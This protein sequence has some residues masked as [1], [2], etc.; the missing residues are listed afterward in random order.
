M[1]Y[2]YTMD[3]VAIAIFILLLVF[4]WGKRKIS[5]QIYVVYYI[6]IGSML[7]STIM[8]VVVLQTMQDVALWGVKTLS[9]ATML[10]ILLQRLIITSCTMY[11]ISL[12]KLDLRSNVLRRC[13]VTIPYAIMALLV[14]FSPW[15]H[16]IFFIDVNGSFHSGSLKILSSL[17]GAYYLAICAWTMFRYRK[18]IGFDKIIFV[19]NNCA[20]IFCTYF[21]QLMMKETRIFALMMALCMIGVVYT[22]QRPDEV[23]DETN[24]LYRD[25]FLD[26]VLKDYS[27]KKPFFVIFIRIH[28]YKILTDS[29][30]QDAVNEILADVTSF[31]TLFTKGTNV[32]RTD[33]DILAIKTEM[34]NEEQLNS[35]VRA[36]SQRFKRIWRNGNTK[37]MLSASFIQAKCP[38]EV[39]NY[40][41]FIRLLGIIERKKGN[42]DELIAAVELLGQDREKEIIEA[43]KRGLEK[44]SFEV[45]YQPIYSTKYKKIIAA[46]ALVR[47]NDEKLGYISPEIMVPIAEREG[48]ILDIGKMV[49]TEVC[50]FYKE[51]NLQEK[52]IEYIE[53]NL[54]VKQC[55]Q[56][57]LAEDFLHI[58]KKYEIDAKQINFEI[59]ESSAMT[60]NH[61]VA[62]NI[63]EFEKN[64]VS[65]SLDDYG[66]GYSN[67][68]YLYQLPFQ[69][70]K[71]DKSILW[72]SESN[73][74]ADATLRNIFEMSKKLDL[75][76]VVEGVETEEQIS[77]LL[78]LGCDYFQ[79]YFFS[80]PVTGKE[81]IKY[82][83]DF[84]LPE[85]CR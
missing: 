47:L 37:A 8:D 12:A 15:T 33:D 10:Y 7:F 69:I 58:M 25:I 83:N 50:R 78:S 30:G 62:N 9:V 53:V 44:K 80:K 55:M 60:T 22:V 29:V 75:H 42:A 14:V 24:A 59:T 45:H 3:Y 72:S 85:I 27:S 32:F 1:Q 74:K 82:V 76:V 26:E 43:I 56:H 52:G 79:G 70:L 54:S 36:I 38:G 64:G 20:V 46:E 13:S 63:S 67:V 5:L 84:Q 68:S 35:T 40:D 65:L 17:Y 71:V 41:E 28:D 19:L 34:M 6:L 31:L 4:F 61:V 66:T 73:K 48:Y 11:V 21:I 23:F 16:W 81:Y 51:N 18:A 77:K 49:F 57:R 39:P 2:N